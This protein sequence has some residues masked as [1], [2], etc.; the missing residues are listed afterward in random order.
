MTMARSTSRPRAVRNEFRPRPFHARRHHG[1]FPGPDGRV[2]CVVRP[3]GYASIRSPEPPVAGMSRR[4]KALAAL[5]LTAAR[6]PI[7]RD[8][9]AFATVALF[10]FVFLIWSAYAA[11]RVIQGRLQ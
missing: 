5:I 6:S 9:L 7:A 3:L 10:I 4:L 1:R 8:V 2:G 11:D